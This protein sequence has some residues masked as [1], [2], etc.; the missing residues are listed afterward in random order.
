L[1]TSESAC[2]VREVTSESYLLAFL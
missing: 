2:D 1:T